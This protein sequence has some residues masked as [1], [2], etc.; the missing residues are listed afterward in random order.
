VELLHWMEPPHAGYRPYFHE[1][2][3]LA[4]TIRKR[5]R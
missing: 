4:F 1:H 3:V 5:T 2:E